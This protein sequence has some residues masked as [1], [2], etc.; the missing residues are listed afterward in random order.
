MK[1]FRTWKL[2]LGA[3]ASQPRVLP[4]MDYLDLDTNFRKLGFTVGFPMHKAVDY[5]LIVIWFCLLAGIGYL[6]GTRPIS[7]YVMTGAI[8]IPLVGTVPL[9][10]NPQHMQQLFDIQL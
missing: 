2:R 9:W 7:E 6:P 10:S 4:K 1:D 3:S 8:Q 5:E